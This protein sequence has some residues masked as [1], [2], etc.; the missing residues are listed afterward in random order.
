MLANV[1]SLGLSSVAIARQHVAAGK[2]VPVAIMGRERSAVLPQ[3]STL[4]ELGFKDLLYENS[5]WM[6][7]LVPAR[8]PAAVV[9]RMGQELR[10]IAN[11]PDARAPLLE[12]CFEM[13]VATP[14]QAP[15]SHRA[16]FDVITRR[17]RE[18]GIEPR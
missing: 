4:S 15:A 14:E 7:M 2:V 10:S 17:I 11:Q 9:Q 16:E 1:V 12:R 3:V 6:A 8:T 13:L 18:L 5:V